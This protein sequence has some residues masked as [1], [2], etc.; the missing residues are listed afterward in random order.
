[1]TKTAEREAAALE[2]LLKVVERCGCGDGE[3]IADAL[4]RGAA[5]GDTEAAAVLAFL[6]ARNGPWPIN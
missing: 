2:A 4:A 6:K 1:M 5:A 3:P